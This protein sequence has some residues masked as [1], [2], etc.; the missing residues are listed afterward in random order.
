MKKTF[1][2]VIAGV[3]GQG[4]VTLNQI[5]AEAAKAEG[6]DVKTSELHGL[7]QRGGSVET[8]IRFGDK[9]YSPLVA[10][11]EADLILGLE[12][13]EGLR[14][15]PYAGKKTV[16]LIN[17]FSLPFFGG[18]SEKE[19][20]KKIGTL[21]KTRKYLVPA[22]NIC[23]KEFGSEVVSG[24]YLLGQAVFKKI[25]PLKPKTVLSAIKKVVPEKHFELNKKAFSS[26]K[27][28]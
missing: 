25:I 13:L 26:S 28:G 3:G 14:A 24:I 27:N 16:F 12:M 21:I 9:I 10:L 4:L 7:S 8:H 23:K 18:F 11:G 5:L 1:N 6:F 17:K 20:L 15:L 2:I 19:V 22:S